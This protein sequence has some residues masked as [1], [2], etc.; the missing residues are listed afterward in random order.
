MTLQVN[1]RLDETDW[2]RVIAAMPGLSNAERM[3]RIVQNHLTLLDA[4]HDL[5]RAL[6]LVEAALDPALQA[7][8]HQRL[9]GRGSEIAE[10]LAQCATEMTAMVLAHSRA[11]ASAPAKHLPELETALVRRWNRS[12]LQLL[13]TAILD[14]TRVCSQTGVQPEV[15]RLL[16]QAVTLAHASGSSLASNESNPHPVQSHGKPTA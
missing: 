1:A 15:R 13:Q 8:R 6:E 7:L 11:L 3:S 10:N 9:H 14:P 16:E 12:T 2:E 5:K 4:Q